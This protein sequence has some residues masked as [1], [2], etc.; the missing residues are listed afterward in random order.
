MEVR[1]HFTGVASLLASCGFQG[2]D[3]D[4]KIWQQAPSPTESCHKL[5]SSGGVCMH[6]C[7]CTAAFYFCFN[8]RPV[9]TVTQKTLRLKQSSCPSPL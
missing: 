4:C 5:C 8:L 6:V 2:P 3:S 9:F 7:V 1:G